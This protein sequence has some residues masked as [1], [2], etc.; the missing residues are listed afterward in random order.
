MDLLAPRALLAM[1]VGGGFLGSIIFLFFTA[2]GLAAP[3]QPNSLPEVP[4][5]RGRAQ[6]GGAG[7]VIDGD[8]DQSDLWPG[9]IGSVLANGKRWSP[10][11]RG[12]PRQ[13]VGLREEL[14]RDQSRP[15]C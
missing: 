10:R 12:F 11:R 7:F 3:T 6:G 14:G 15:G 8:L 4:T 9:Q 2:A 5:R 1:G 13:R